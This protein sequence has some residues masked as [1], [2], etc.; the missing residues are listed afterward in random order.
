MDHIVLDRVVDVL[1]ALRLAHGF[2][3]IAQPQHRG[4]QRLPQGRLGRA[5]RQ[6][7]PA[8]EPRNQSFVFQLAQL[9]RTG[10]R[11]TPQFGQRPLEQHHARRQRAAGQRL[12]QQVRDAGI[13]RVLA[14]VPGKENSVDMNVFV[15]GVTG[16]ASLMRQTES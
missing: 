16:G 4:R 2:A 14:G 6:H 7:A 15:D 1:P 13:E 9:W 10:L 11:V 3:L 12:A 5:A 8:V